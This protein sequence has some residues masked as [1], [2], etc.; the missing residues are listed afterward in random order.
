MV[1][2]CDPYRP[3]LGGRET[4]CLPGGPVSSA[5]SMTR[6]QANDAV[7]PATGYLRDAFLKPRAEAPIATLLLNSGHPSTRERESPRGLPPVGREQPSGLA[8]D[9]EI[10]LQDR[11]RG[12]RAEKPRN[13]RRDA[14]FRH[15]GGGPPEAPS[16]KPKRRRVSATASVTPRSERVQT[17][18]SRPPRGFRAAVLWLTAPGDRRSGRHDGLGRAVNS[19]VPLPDRS[20]SGP[21]GPPQRVH[22]LSPEAITGTCRFDRET[23]LPPPGLNGATWQDQNYLNLAPYLSAPSR[24]GSSP[25]RG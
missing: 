22:G 17:V 23:S 10:R 2:V 25:T 14:T 3:T 12:G 20:S 9:P 5:D 11:E 24:A 21:V 18:E 16:R 1:S 4:D 7:S 6:L 8:S 19:G 13:A 15:P